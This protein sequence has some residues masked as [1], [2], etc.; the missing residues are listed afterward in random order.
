MTSTT[1][2]VV[3]PTSPATQPGSPREGATHSTTSGQG[4][5][6]SSAS[7]ARQFAR[8]RNQTSVDQKVAVFESSQGNA[9]AGS[10]R[11]IYRAFL[12]DARFSDHTFIWALRTPIARALADAGF[13]VEGLSSSGRD[14]GAVLELELALGETALSELRRAKIVVWG[15]DEYRRAFAHAGYWVTDGLLADYLV[16]RLCQSLVQTWRGTPLRR[17]GCDLPETEENLHVR[18]ALESEGRRL[19]YLVS[20]SQYASEKFITAMCLSR[21]KRGSAIVEIGRPGADALV[22]P[23]PEQLSA[24][25]TR[26]ELPSNKRVALVA[27]SPSVEAGASQGC[28]PSLD[29]D[30]LEREL[31]EDFVLLLRG[32]DVGTSAIANSGEFARDVTSVSDINDLFLV[33]DVLVTDFS[34]A[35]F[36]YALLSRPIVLYVADD[37]PGVSH[38]HGLYLDPKTLPARCAFTDEDLIAALRAAIV[39]DPATDDSQAALAAFNERFNPFADGTASE[40]TVAKIAFK[41]P[42]VVPPRTL[43]QRANKQLRSVVKRSKKSIKRAM[44]SASKRSSAVRAVTRTLLDAKRGAN[45]RKHRRR[46]PINANMIVFESFVGWKYSV[47][48][49]RALRSGARGTRG[50]T[51]SLSFGHSK[52]PTRTATSPNFAERRSFGTDRR[53]TTPLTRRPSTGSPIRSYSRTCSFA[54]DRCTFRR[55]T[56]PRSSGSDVTSRSSPRA[57]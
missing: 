7:D 12:A 19:T 27:P 14:E 21:K 53:S 5:P 20:P 42:I 24:I 16:P 10:P 17:F 47:Q 3:S 4:R 34:G 57:A 37:E 49:S 32:C 55:G 1:S 52:T 6:A 40:R 45:Y 36:D 11:G 33:S 38:D 46:A 28:M 29:L 31:G 18:E 8:V 56:E 13:D 22:A 30:A 39:D 43:A 2:K 35:L 50:L 25:R 9:Y 54:M 41:D 51:T 15:S 48:P 44:F 26:L 23:P